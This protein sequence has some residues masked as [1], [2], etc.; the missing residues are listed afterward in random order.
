MGACDLKLHSSEQV[1]I[2]HLRTGQGW[3][4]HTNN[5][6]PEQQ[7]EEPKMKRAGCWFRLRTC[8]FVF[9]GMVATGG[10]FTEGL[11]H[12]VGSSAETRL[13]GNIDGAGRFVS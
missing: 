12:S 4:W 11:H 8:P 3:V 10:L 9:C 5:K 7:W 13:L 2:G 1:H 6:R